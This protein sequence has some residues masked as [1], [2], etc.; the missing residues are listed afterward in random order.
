[1]AYAAKAAW[2]G[3]PSIV[4]RHSI[5]YCGQNLCFRMRSS[6]L[7]P[8]CKSNSDEC[9]AGNPQAAICGSG[10]GDYPGDPVGVGDRHRY[11]TTESRCSGAKARCRRSLK[12]CD[13]RPGAGFPPVSPSQNIGAKRIRFAT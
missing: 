5:R 9:G 10:G 11:S 7:W 3:K 1:M 6:K 8:Y 4:S 2:T 12:L 13:T